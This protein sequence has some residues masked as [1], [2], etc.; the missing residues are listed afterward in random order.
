MLKKKKYPAYISKHNSNHEKE[1]ILLTI[2]NWVGWNYR[3]VKK[4]SA[5]LRG[6][7]FVSKQT[8]MS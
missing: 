2:P 7:I 5:L 1:V 8:W 3:A 4:L 6:I